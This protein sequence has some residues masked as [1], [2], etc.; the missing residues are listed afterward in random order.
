MELNADYLRLAL[1]VAGSA[2]VGALLGWIGVRA[3]SASAMVRM[4]RQLHDDA[5]ALRAALREE[6]ARLKKALLNAP[7]LQQLPKQPVDAQMVAAVER[8]YVGLVGWAQVLAQSSVDEYTTRRILNG[9]QSGVVDGSLDAYFAQSRELHHRARV[10]ASVLTEN[11]IYVD[12]ELH[13]EVSQAVERVEQVS[14]AYRTAARACHEG[15]DHLDARDFLR[16]F[17]QV[18]A[19]RTQLV[20]YC[21]AVFVPLVRDRLAVRFRQIRSLYAIAH[22]A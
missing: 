13:G 11:A 4:H 21:D 17:H 3:W 12:A 2:L 15:R 16:A 18:E 20:D 22:A 19:A 14:R 9:E 1:Y 6:A 5:E 10:L 7:F 8:I